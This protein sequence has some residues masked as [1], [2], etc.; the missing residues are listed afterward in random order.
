MN[1]DWSLWCLQ[2][3]LRSFTL[4][5]LAFYSL[6][7]KR[8]EIPH[9]IIIPEVHFALHKSY[10]IQFC[11]K[12]NIESCHTP[13]AVL[14]CFTVCRLSHWPGCV[15]FPRTNYSKPPSPGVFIPLC[16]FSLGMWECCLLRKLLC[17][18]EPGSE[19]PLSLC[20]DSWTHDTK[21]FC[22]LAKC[23]PLVLQSKCGFFL[24][25]QKH[26]LHSSLLCRVRFLLLFLTEKKW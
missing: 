5:H 4:G 10:W 11:F 6:F 17:G 12:A 7:L 8:G 18:S 16:L 1:L 22:S 19:Q 13:P 15:C 23:D 2:A 25:F 20:F 14:M 9:I 24:S 3:A 26:S 21:S